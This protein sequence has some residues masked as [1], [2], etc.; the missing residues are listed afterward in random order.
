MVHTAEFQC[1]IPCL[2]L[3]YLSGFHFL[4]HI[5]NAGKMLRDAII[6]AIVSLI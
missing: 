1:S 2:K 6:S 4:N 3:A 5:T